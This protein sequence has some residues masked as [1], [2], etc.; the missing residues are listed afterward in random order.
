MSNRP[1]LATTVK[2]PASLVRRLR[3]PTRLDRKVTVLAWCSFVA[4]VLVIATGGAVRL[5][6]SGLGCPTWPLCTPESLVN[7]PEMGIHG[8]IEFGNRT[9]TGLV[10]GL[11]LALLL[12]VFQLR[13]QR[14]DL[15]ILA[16]SVLVGVMA[17][18]LVGGITVLTGLNP[19]I[20]GFHYLASLT[21]VCLSALFVDRL[22]AGA[23]TPAGL[24]SPRWLKN[25][26]WAT[27]SLTAVTVVLGVLTTGAGPH[28]GDAAAGR[29]GFNAVILQHVHAWP[30]YLL[31]VMTL[32]L[33]LVLHSKKHESWKWAALLAAI[34]AMQAALGIF[35][36]RNGLPELAVGFHMVLASLLA[37]TT[38]VIFVRTQGYLK[39]Q[40]QQA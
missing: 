28:S 39:S 20:V 22:G 38:A 4:Q 15:Y 17:Q 23:R 21:L 6:S 8:L 11:A 34:Q 10:G 35:Q 31:I 3:L 29:N 30:S 5:T 33:A 1:P 16:S 2:N 18:A 40:S 26:L 19:F 13:A 32:L 37:A 25:S 14:K 24:A 27:A 12:C 7:T 9:L 36:A